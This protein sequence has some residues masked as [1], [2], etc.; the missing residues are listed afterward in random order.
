MLDDSGS[1]N[2]K[3]W[4]DLM[5]AFT[6]FIDILENDINLKN[7]SKITVINH[8]ESSIIYFKE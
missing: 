5:R 3:P 8:N 6:K 7:N 2:G 4:Q 1:M